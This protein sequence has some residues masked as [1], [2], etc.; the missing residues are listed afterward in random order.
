MC[1]LKA[2]LIVCY[3]EVRTSAVSCGALLFSVTLIKHLSGDDRRKVTSFEC[4]HTC[5]IV[6]TIL[7]FERD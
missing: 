6:G 2:N 5:F 7:V 3:K 4:R 1:V